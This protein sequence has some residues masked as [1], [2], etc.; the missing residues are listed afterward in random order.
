[1][2][3]SNLRTMRILMTGASGFLGTA[4]TTHFQD[5]GDE[6]V[7]AVRRTPGQG[8]IQWNPDGDT[9]PDVSSY[10]VVIHLAG[11]SIGAKRW[12]EEQKREIL[13]SRTKGTTL[14]AEA[15]AR[16]D[17]RPILLNA[18]AIGYYGDKGD[19]VLTEDSLPGDDFQAEVVQKWEAATA[20]ASE[21]GAR[22][23]LMRSGLVLSDDGGVLTRMLF[24]FKLGLG[25]RIGSG[26]QWMS[27]ISL[28]DEVR[29]ID[30]LLTSELSGPVN[31]TAP[32]PVTN[33]EFTDTLGDVLG[34]PTILPTPLLPLKAVYGSELVESLLLASQRVVGTKLVDSGF[35]FTHEKLSE[36]LRAEVD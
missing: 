21:A 24:P 1:M 32:N 12:T 20:P 35:S 10:D 7:A 13:E 15:I 19:E 29:A 14:V 23:V 26:K 25:G 34:R 2:D 4:L 16:A 33:Q 3:A 18:S 31:L 30:Y 8:E 28:T 22:V 17:E 27:W 36:G 11:E 5:K 6:V 9:F